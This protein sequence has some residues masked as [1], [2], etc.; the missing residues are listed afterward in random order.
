MMHLLLA[1][2]CRAFYIL[3][4]SSSG[5]RSCAIAGLYNKNY[6]KRVLENKCPRI[7]N[8]FISFSCFVL[9]LVRQV[10]ARKRREGGDNRDFN[11][12][13]SRD[14]L[15]IRMKKY[16]YVMTTNVHF[17]ER[18]ITNT[19]DRKKTSNKNNCP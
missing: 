4:F 12:S 5:S 11:F 2:E 9:V 3:L 15:N 16:L 10:S 8:S 14:S 17:R 19:T 13:H 18:K 7:D 6:S 1:S